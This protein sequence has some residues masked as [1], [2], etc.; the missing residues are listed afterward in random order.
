MP[1]QPYPVESSM[2]LPA[3]KRR[4]LVALAACAVPAVAACSGAAAQVQLPPKSQRVAAATATSQPAPTA[5]DEVLA[6]VTGFTAALAEADRSGDAATARQLL[7][8][9]LVADR[10]DGLVK[11]ISAIWAK[12]D[13][14]YGQDA[15]HVLTVTIEGRR[16]FVHDCD[17]T[18]SMG[19]ENAATGQP[20]PG[21]A[22]IADD[23]IVTRLELVNGRWLVQ[24]Q[25]IEDVSC[26]P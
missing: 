6:A 2:T 11:A 24:D 21:S 14:F 23:N 7:R 26:A 19:L 20:V 1:G 9:F 17:N 13:R 12:G 25:L 4:A 10:V 3:P 22:G 15:L 16:A 8:P 5:R 18:S